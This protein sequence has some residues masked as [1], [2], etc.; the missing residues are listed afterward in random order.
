MIENVDDKILKNIDPNGIYLWKWISSRGKSGGI[1]SGVNNDVLE[2]G[3]FIE[4][5]YMLQMTLWDTSKKIKW[6]FINVYGSSQEENKR[7]FL[8]KL[9]DF[10]SKNKL[11][12]IV[13][14]DFNIIRF[15]SEK[16]KPSSLS[17][18]SHLFNNIISIYELIDIHMVGGRFTWSNN[19]DVPTLE[20]LDR[21]LMSKGWDDSFPNV[22]ALKL[23]REHSDHNPLILS[24]HKTVHHRKISFRFEL[25]WLKDPDFV[26]C[27][28]NI[29][30]KPCH[31]KSAL[32]RI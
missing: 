1:L 22:F 5:K 32:D 8:T 30:D 3:S 13:G 23:S 7:E 31:A 15:T 6:N 17:K 14:G 11:P 2:V 24:T 19:L 16:N 12:F 25:S 27:V 4:G 28:K 20:R 10:C 26:R 21:I 9:A 18:H 29:W